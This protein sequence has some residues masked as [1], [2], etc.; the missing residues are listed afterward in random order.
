MERIHIR[1]HS[2]ALQSTTVNMKF[3]VEGECKHISM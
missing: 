1:V 3:I 2:E